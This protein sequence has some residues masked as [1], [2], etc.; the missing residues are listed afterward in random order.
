MKLLIAW[1]AFF[2]SLKLFISIPVFTVA[3]FVGAP[4]NPGQLESHFDNVSSF[5]AELV[6][7]LAV[8]ALLDLSRCVYVQVGR[9]HRRG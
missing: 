3:L 5:M 1:A 7:L 9:V 4:F 8:K 6:I 2:H